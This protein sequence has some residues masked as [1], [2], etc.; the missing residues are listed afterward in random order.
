M[1]MRMLFIVGIAMVTIPVRASIREKGIAN[2]Y[3]IRPCCPFV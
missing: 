1:D 3:V 2:T